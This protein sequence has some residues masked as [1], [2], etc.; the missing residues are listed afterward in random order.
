M[1]RIVI[2]LSLV[3]LIPTI[4]LLVVVAVAMFLKGDVLKGVMASAVVVF[5]VWYCMRPLFGTWEWDTLIG[6][7]DDG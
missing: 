1:R 6:G 3:V 2:V 5:L 4:L 7:D